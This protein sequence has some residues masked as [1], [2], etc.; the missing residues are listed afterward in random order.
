VNIRNLTVLSLL[1]LAGL[2]AL[3]DPVDVT[4]T[5]T[6]GAAEFGYYVGPY[7]GTIDGDPV[8]LYCVDFI[9]EVYQGETWEANLTPLDGGDLSNTR[10]G[11]AVGLPNALTLYEEAAWLTT[12]YA[13]NPNDYGD[14]QATI[15]QLFDPDAPSPSSDY[16]AQLAAQN[17]QSV[18][19]AAFD[20]VTNVAPVEA[21]GQ[22]Q[23]FLIDPAPVPEPS[24]LL[25]L[26]SLV[27]LSAWLMRR[28]LSVTARR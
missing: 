8:T 22:V 24:S 19:L 6:N 2:P 13:S 7:Y 1:V 4:F 16:W 11:G 9:N 12:Q 17:Y 10:F 20:V 18:D 23:E 14:I 15:W 5:G 3:A 21:T 27:A 25:L 28:R 26:A